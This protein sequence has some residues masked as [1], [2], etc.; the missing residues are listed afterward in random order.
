M[1][2][3]TAAAGLALGDRLLG[4]SAWVGLGDGD[5]DEEVVEEVA[6]VVAV[7]KVVDGALG[8]AVVAGIVLELEVAEEEARVRV[9]DATEVVEAGGAWVVLVVPSASL[10]AV[11]LVEA[12]RLGVL[13]FFGLGEGF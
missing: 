10:P 8:V 2:L 6:V 12:A 1:A 4:P 9:V 11:A 3:P 7:T 5:C 13:A